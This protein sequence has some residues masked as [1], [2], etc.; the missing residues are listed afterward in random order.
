MN[1]IRINTVALGL[2][3]P[4][5]LPT[6]EDAEAAGFMSYGPDIR[7]LYRRAADIVDKILRGTKPADI[8]VEQPTNPTAEWLA[9]QITEAFAWDSAPKYLIRD[10]D[11]AFGVAFNARVRA[12]GIRDRPTSFRSPW[13]NGYVERLIGS[14]RHECTY[15][16]IVFN[17]EH[18]RRI[19]AKYAKLLQ[20]GTDSRF[21]REG[22][23]LHAR[24]RAVRRHCCVSH[25]RRATQSLCTN[26]TFR[27]RQ[28]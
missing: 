6:R 11:S 1:R 26:L 19:L 15:H 21:T 10:N 27:K 5:V 22:C 2:R 20:L 8:P 7:D 28:R 4:T 3:L 16:L 17:A 18:L 23:A 12:M 24:D 25:A 9:R 13:Q 14:I